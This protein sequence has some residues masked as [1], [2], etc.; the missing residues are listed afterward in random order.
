MGSTV[1]KSTIVKGNA[2]TIGKLIEVHTF[3]DNSLF[4]EMIIGCAKRG[5]QTDVKQCA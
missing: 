5:S 1:S 4:E 3:G 2:H